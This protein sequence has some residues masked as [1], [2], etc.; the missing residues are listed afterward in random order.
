MH[1]SI[2]LEASRNSFKLIA[3][4]NNRGVTTRGLFDGGDQERGVAHQYHAWS[5]ALK[6]DWPRTSSLHSFF[7]VSIVHLLNDVTDW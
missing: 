1:L 6:L 2:R 3:I 4:H 7:D 5:D